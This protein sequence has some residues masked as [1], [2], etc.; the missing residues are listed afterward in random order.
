MNASDHQ[1]PRARIVAGPTPLVHAPRLSAELGIDLFIKRDDLAGPTLGGN[2]SRQLEY[3]FG[4]ALAEQADTILITGAVQ[5]NFARLAAAVARSF[6]M[7][8]EVQLER[9]V[10]TSS[11]LYATSGNV[12]LNRVVGA[13][14]ASYPEGEDEAGADTA[15]ADRAKELRAKGRRPYV[16]PL[17]E[18][19]PP[20]GA[21]G[22]V[23]AAQ[24]ILAQD[25]G[26]DVFV[27]ASGSGSTH[28]GLLAGLRGAGSGA[29]VLGSCVR[30]DARQ[31]KARIGRVT[32]RL[33]GMRRDVGAVD[34][35]D[36][37][38]WDGALAPGYGQIGP[39]AAQAI[40][41]MAHQEG[42]LLDPVYTA[43]GFAAIPALVSD[44]TIRPGA[45][46]CFVHTGG[47][48]AL[49]AYGDVLGG[50]F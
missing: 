35:D 41:M 22:Y 48:A 8:A 13:H 38:L 29:D 26:F 43:K 1:P 24:E 45:R 36:I 12:L 28:S 5:S 7:Q 3:H 33:G 44:G 47:L 15:L 46:V 4:A 18:G 21:L 16:I 19:H 14:V 25:A 31:Q 11:D 34:D 32:R 23:D 39:R 17:S 27:V 37:R 50:L 42:L 6:G 49:F 2:K 30:R 20:L 10:S 40:R 9:R